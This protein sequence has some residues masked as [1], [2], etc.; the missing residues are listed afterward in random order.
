MEM[1]GVLA[2]RKIV[3]A[4]LEADTGPLLPQDDG[5]HGFALGV[6]EFDFGFGCAR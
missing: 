1:D 5:A 3:Q 2:G 4:K 6:L